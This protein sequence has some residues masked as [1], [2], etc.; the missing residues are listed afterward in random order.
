MAKFVFR[1]LA[2]EHPDPSDFLTFANDVVVGEIAPGKF[3]TMIYLTV[4]PETGTLVA[5]CA[6]H[7]APLLVAPDG[8]VTQLEV[9]GLALGVDTGQEYE[10]ATATLE[11][12]GCAVVFT[13]GVIEARRDGELYGTERLVAVLSAARGLSPAEIARA[14]IDDCR[15]Y[16]GELADDCAVV[17][18]KKKD[19]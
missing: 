8:A 5:A 18:I 19:E 14:V 1:S 9:K 11:P 17:V 3:I 12:G 13:D 15:L 6:G 16:A 7:P 4:E 10:P 2:R